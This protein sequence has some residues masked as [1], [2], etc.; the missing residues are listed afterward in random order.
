MLKFKT[1][2]FDMKYYETG[3]FS[4]DIIMV[5]H[6]TLTF[7]WSIL[8]HSCS[9]L[10]PTN[11]NTRSV[12]KNSSVDQW[13]K[14]KSLQNSPILCLDQL[15]SQLH[16]C[17]RHYLAHLPLASKITRCNTIVKIGFEFKKRTLWMSAQCSV[18]GRKTP[19]IF[20]LP[21]FLPENTDW[22]LCFVLT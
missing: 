11:I 14:F 8:L 22:L 5:V 13:I 6:K 19:P 21:L 16:R 4:K 1:F 18:A 10:D 9:L 3:Q 2:N 20:A 17:H 7:P 15:M 12:I